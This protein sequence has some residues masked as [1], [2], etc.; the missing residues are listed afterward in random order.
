MHSFIKFIIYYT[1]FLL[2]TIHNKILL[3][4]DDATNIRSEH[5][6][7]IYLYISFINMYLFYNN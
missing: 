1:C 6:F 4:E 3:L 5:A 7:T 2:I